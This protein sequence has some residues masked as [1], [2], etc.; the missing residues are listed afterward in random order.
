MVNELR[1]KPMRSVIFVASRRKM[2]DQFLF[3]GST[4]LA[5]IGCFCEE[6]A[7]AIRKLALGCK[8]GCLRH[9]ES[10]GVYSRSLRVSAMNTLN[11]FNR[12]KLLL[13]KMRGSWAGCL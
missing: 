13:P 1:L 2:C 12:L 8:S 3:A 7:I 6:D 4:V 11:L 5:A 9:F 10:A